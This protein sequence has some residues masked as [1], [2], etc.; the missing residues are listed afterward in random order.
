[1]DFD[2]IPYFNEYEKLA[3]AADAMFEKIRKEYPD[4]VKCEMKCA[5]CCHALFD[6][7][8]I[9]AIYINHQFNKN[10]EGKEAEKKALLEKANRA[11]RQ[12]YK[13]KKKAF[14]DLQEGKE[15]ALILE[16]MGKERIRCPLLNESDQCD[17]YEYRPITCRLY[18]IPTAI[19]GKG[20]TCGKSAFKPGEPYPTANMD[21]IYQRLYTLSDDLIGEIQS[22]HQKMGELLVPLSMSLLTVY[23][24]E[25]LGIDQPGENKDRDGEKENA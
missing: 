22:R 4:C 11:D 3:L 7:T 15:E 14:K 8:L 2:F 12:V 21:M 10:F 13:I 23:D 19:N 16:E 9:E 1:M 25:Y 20:H 24:E 5:D 6:L 18:G 17:L